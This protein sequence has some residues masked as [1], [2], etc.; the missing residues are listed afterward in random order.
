VLLYSVNLVPLTQIFAI[1]HTKMSRHELTTN[2]S[3]YTTRTTGIMI[4]S[5]C[6]TYNLQLIILLVVLLVEGT[7]IEPELRA[8][9]PLY[10]D[11]VE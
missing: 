4:T 3:L 2:N 8:H 9:W 10:R 11:P 1:S 5:H 6:S 7:E